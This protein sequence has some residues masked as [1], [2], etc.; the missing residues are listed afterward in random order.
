ME[1]LNLIPNLVTRLVLQRV[2][3]LVDEPGTVD[4]PVGIPATPK[5]PGFLKT[6]PG[7]FLLALSS[8]EADVY[9]YADPATLLHRCDVPRDF[10]SRELALYSILAKHYAKLSIDT[11]R[12]RPAQV[13]ARVLKYFNVA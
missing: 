9:L 6:I 3:L 11:G 12:W 10:L 2:C 7:R 1:F 5:W 13:V 8:R 4:S